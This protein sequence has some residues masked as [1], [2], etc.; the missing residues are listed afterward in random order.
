MLG[1][2]LVY[3]FAS[4]LWML[5]LGRVI[6]GLGAGNQVV[7]QVYFTWSTNNDD[8]SLIMGIMSLVQV[9]AVIIGPALAPAFGAFN[10]HMWGPY[11]L[12]AMTLPGHFSALLTIITIVLL[13]FFKEMP[14]PPSSAEP[15]SNDGKSFGKKCLA[16]FAP[17]TSA[18][19][20]G[21]LTCVILSFTLGVSYTVFEVVGPQ[22]CQDFY[23]GW[24]DTKTGILYAVA[25][26]EAIVVIVIQTAFI[27]KRF[28]DKAVV[29]WSS[30]GIA[31][32]GVFF[33]PFDFPSFHPNGFIPFPVFVVGAAVSTAAFTIGSVVLLTLFSRL[34]DGSEGQGI[35]MG[36]FNASR[37]AS[38]VAAPIVVGILWNIGG[39][40]MVFIPTCIVLFMGLWMNI[41]GYTSMDPPTAL[42]IQSD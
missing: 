35:F 42:R 26:L 15:T 28:S 30:I 34:I 12:D 22:L 38:R 25:G 29:M 2:N 16:W 27:S 13:I 36:Y 7:S 23:P 24:D 11:Y 40:Y 39:A 10:I 19:G 6:V 31:A 32:S 37:A 9:A 8:R 5:V 4:T 41:A 18:K 33:T 1:G 21:I 3:G 20:L 14:R 17:E